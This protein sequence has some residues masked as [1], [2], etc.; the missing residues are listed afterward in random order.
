MAKTYTYTA[1][2][3][4]NPERVVTFTL[5]DSRMSVGVGAPLEQV[6][7]AIQLGRGEEEPEEEQVEGEVEVAVEE[8]E[9]PKL[10]L[11]PVAVSLV[12]RGT[13]PVHVD[14]VV[15]KLTG[16]WLT[17]KSWIRTGGLRLIPITLIDGRVDN[18][19]AAEDFV[20]EIEERKSVTG[21][22]LFGLFDYWATWIV[23]AL[24]ALAM[25]QK[26]RRKGSEKQEG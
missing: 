7:R 17:V 16:E 11:R 10:W 23:T 9:E 6:E 26:W 24:L 14:D 8:T 18:P 5:R 15:A 4:E 22:N 25:F 3:A 2:S 19:V 21:F 20:K 13:G 1:R 12:E